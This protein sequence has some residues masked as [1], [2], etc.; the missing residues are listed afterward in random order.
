[1]LLRVLPEAEVTTSITPKFG[2]ESVC[3]DCRN[4]IRFTGKFWEHIGTAYRHP[5]RPRVRVADT[6]SEPQPATTPIDLDPRDE[7]KTHRRME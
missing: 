7:N 3:V 2:D 6:R 4:A 1:L 5:A